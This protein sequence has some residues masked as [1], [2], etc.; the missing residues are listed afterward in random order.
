M[1]GYPF[2]ITKLNVASLPSSDCERL[3]DVLRLGSFESSGVAVLD[4]I[5]RSWKRLRGL[6]WLETIYDGYGWM[7]MEE[8]GRGEE[9]LLDKKCNSWLI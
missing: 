7:L 2:S 1:S 6:Q 3:Q 8:V 9:R 5:C 4:D